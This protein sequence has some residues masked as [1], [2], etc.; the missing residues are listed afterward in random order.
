MIRVIEQLHLT[1]PSQT[2]K[3]S[4]EIPLRTKLQETLKTQSLMLKDLSV[5]NSQSKPY[6]KT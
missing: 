4:L 1:L 3:D 6:K 2:M 5:E